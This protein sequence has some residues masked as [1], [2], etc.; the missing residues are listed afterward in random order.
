[1]QIEQSRRRLSD[2][3][4]SGRV[5]LM[6]PPMFIGFAADY[7]VKKTAQTAGQCGRTI[8]IARC[9]LVRLEFRHSLL[10]NPSIAPVLSGPNRK[11]QQGQAAH[12]LHG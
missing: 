1:M 10:G 5:F 7:L 2:G 9:T 8:A 4:L 11:Q 12:A 6:M 3:F